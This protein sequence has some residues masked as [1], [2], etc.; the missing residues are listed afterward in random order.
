MIG[1]WA[2]WTGAE[3]WNVSNGGACDNR[4]AHTGVERQGEG[5]AG[6]RRSRRDRLVE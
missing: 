4:D 6:V 1:Y 3:P 2:S 5:A